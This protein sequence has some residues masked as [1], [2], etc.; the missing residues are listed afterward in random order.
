MRVHV[1]EDLVSKEGARSSGGVCSVLLKWLVLKRA[2][3][4]YGGRGFCF[5]ASV[6]LLIY[7][8]EKRDMVWGGY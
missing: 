6:K 2:M 5:S 1:V 4:R 8:E 3:H 7:F